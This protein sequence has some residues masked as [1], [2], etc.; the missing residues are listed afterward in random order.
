MTKL[1]VYHS[2]MHRRPQDYAYFQALQPSVYKVM[3]GGPNDYEWARNNLPNALIIARDW[4][5]SEQHSDMLKAPAETGIR[6]AREW[7]E[8]QK[9]LGFDK[10]KTLVL[11]INE[12]KVWEPGVSEALRLYTVAMCGEAAKLGLR[13]GAM[14]LS[15]GW[16]NNTG[17]DTPPDWSPWHGVEEAILRNGGALVT[18][19]YFADQGPNENWGWWCGRTLKCPWQVPIVIGE[20]GCD[21]FVKD[22]SVGQQNRG[23]LGHMPPE[24]YAAELAEY[25]QRMS[26]DPR[27]VGCCVFASDFAAHEWYSFDVEPAYKAILANLPKDT[28]PVTTHLP[29]VGTGTTTRY[30][31]APNGLH[32]RAEPKLDGISLVALA[33]GEPVTVLGDLDSQWVRVQYNGQT[34][35]M[36]RSYLGADKPA[37]VAGDGPSPVSG[38]QDNWARAWPI[39][40]SIEGG[41]SLD[42]NDSGNYYDGKL[43]GTKFGI[44]AA[45][46]GGQYD[47]PNLTKEQAL[48]IYKRAYWDAADC[49]IMAWPTCLIVFD[50]AVNHGVGV[51]KQL[52]AYKPTPEEIYLG[53]RALRYVHDPKWATYG[54]AWGRRLKTISDIAKEESSK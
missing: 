42:P 22:T 27:F 25:T 10:A 35:Y 44:S 11:G 46:W 36:Y 52:L 51:A 37:P 34:G 17:P 53:Q 23:W 43:V 50:T 14:Q 54:I 20:C 6:H 15:V 29:A 47:I 33:Y 19:E 21:M 26:A 38:P 2:V 31:T 48:S 40:L 49:H 39:V 4:A 18:H 41:L 13:V 30:V 3:D 1:G 16:P 45:V 32:L 28:P 24:R 9:R 7:N 12:P 5:L 8:H